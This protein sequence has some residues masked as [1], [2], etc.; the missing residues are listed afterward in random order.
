MK[1]VTPRRAKDERNTQRGPSKL[2]NAQVVPSGSPVKVVQVSIAV[3]G[4]TDS[5]YLSDRVGTSL[6]NYTANQTSN[7]VLDMPVQPD[8]TIIFG[9][10]THVYCV[11]DVRGEG[12]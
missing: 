3:T 10:L 4:N 5:G 12:Q 2:H 9:S 8:G 11:V 1:L 7:V 6:H